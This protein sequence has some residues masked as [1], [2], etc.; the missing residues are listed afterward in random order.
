MADL[1]ALLRNAATSMDAQRGLSAVAGNNIQNANTPGYARQR[2]VVVEA[3]P[4]EQVNGAVIGGGAVLTSVQQVRD[5]FVEAQVP[6]TLG[7][8]AASAAESQALQSFHA[9][10]PGATGGLGEAIG[11]F[12]AAL[13]GL[14]QN[15]GDGGLRAA[16]LGAAG[17]L[18][19]A[20]HRTSQSVEA[21]RAGLDAQLGGIA[22]EANT[23]ARAVAALNAQIRRGRA[24]GAEPNDLL[25]QRQAHLDR[26]AE[27]TGA[28][29]V[30]TS[31]GDVN[32]VLARGQP[33]VTGTI[34]SRLQLD[35]TTAAHP[36]LL[37]VDAAGTASPLAAADLS[38]S[39]GGTLAARD[40]GLAAAG[41]A[42]DQL[43][44]QLAGA[45]NAVHQAGVGLDGS[46]GQPLFTGVAA[47]A[48]AAG[49]IAVAVTDPLALATSQD[50]TPGDARNAQALLSTESA[51]LPG[52]QDVQ[53]T[54]STMVAS[55]G[56][57]AQQALAF[58][59]QDEAVRQHVS[60][61]RDAASGV[62]IDE[63]MVQMQQAQRGYEAI[64]KVI[65]T[66]DEMLQTLMRMIP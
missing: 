51:A 55:Y 12:Y 24:G 44:F 52:G 47:Q 61:L 37:L 41:A 29:T 40:G 1:L 56:A 57:V 34:A 26:L 35:R 39:A 32:V 23:E 50:G 63:E 13:Q 33:L 38:G 20:F 30:A 19:N 43:A 54:L 28:T 64:A 21:A 22:D 10:D 17:S 66:A 3:L 14:A 16:F 6:V 2:G 27:L 15:A 9:L 62:S 25:D 53:A 42:V 7:N 8:A 5:R 36:G 65:Q 31:D 48:G 46:T 11:G 59:A 4:A 45:L 60:T 18:V 49:R 58:A